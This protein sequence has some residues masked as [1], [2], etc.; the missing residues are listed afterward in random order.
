MNWNKLIRNLL[1][2][3]ACFAIGYFLTDPSVSD[4]PVIAIAIPVVLIGAGL[5][6][7]RRQK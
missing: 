1:L 4:N 2:G 5:L 6:L 7:S 3:A